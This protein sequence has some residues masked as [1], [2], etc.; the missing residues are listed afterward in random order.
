MRWLFISHAF[1]RDIV[2][3]IYIISFAMG[4]WF[5]FLSSQISQSDSRNYVTT[6]DFQ[7]YG[8]CWSSIWFLLHRFCFFWY[9]WP[10]GSRILRYWRKKNP[11]FWIKTWFK[12][13]F[14]VDTLRL[15]HNKS[16][17]LLT[18]G[19]E[20]FLRAGNNDILGARVGL[21]TALDKAITGS[22]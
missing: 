13:D 17:H 14:D 2:C 3:H 5:C 18:V 9:L 12:P 15:W 1:I 19:M 11:R 21:E 6:C 4:I 7:S 20:S 16:R 22:S 8:R 10:Y